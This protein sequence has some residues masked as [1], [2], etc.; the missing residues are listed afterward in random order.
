[1]FFGLFGSL[2]GQNFKDGIDIS[3]PQMNDALFVGQDGAVFFVNE[4]I[5][6][7]LPTKKSVPVSIA[8][9][10]NSEI[11]KASWK[12]VAVS[13][14]HGKMES[15]TACSGVLRAWLP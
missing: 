10:C 15:R 4:D 13:F 1:M 12:G 9:L 14:K 8:E 2:S 3:L 6:T 11:H 7:A 5:D